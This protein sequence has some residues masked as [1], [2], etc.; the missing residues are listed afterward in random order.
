MFVKTN[1]EIIDRPL[2]RMELIV[3]FRLG[4]ESVRLVHIG[5]TRDVLSEKGGLTFIR[6][7]HIHRGH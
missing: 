7:E 1:R 5:A 6:A 3:L 4:D 2:R